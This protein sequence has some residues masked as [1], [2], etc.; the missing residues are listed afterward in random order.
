MFEC[1][2]LD[3]GLDVSFDKIYDSKEMREKEWKVN[4]IKTHVKS[5]RFPVDLYWC[6]NCDVNLKKQKIISL[7]RLL[8]VQI[9]VP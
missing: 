2:S 1:Y 3:V 5:L 6:C 9:A 7:F 8:T 4:S